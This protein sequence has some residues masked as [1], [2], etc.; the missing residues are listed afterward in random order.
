MCLHAAYLTTECKRVG[1]ITLV[2][3]M[4]GTLVSTVRPIW[5]SVSRR[6]ANTTPPAGS[7][8]TRLVLTSAT[9]L[10]QA[11]TANVLLDSLVT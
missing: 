9:P 3:A 4:T 2:P 5:M 10:Q 1:R 8:R 7:G 6:H 11:L